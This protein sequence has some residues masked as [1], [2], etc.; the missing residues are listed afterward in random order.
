VKS[1]PEERERLIEEA[2]SAH[3]A[4]D[5]RGGL[6]VSPAFADLDEAGRQE[7]FD[8]QILSR[9]LEAALDPGGLSTTARAV[10]ARI[11]AGG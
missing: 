4:A 3:R 2:V 7:A 1:T 8:L 5:P 9:T 10:L 11:R 6:R